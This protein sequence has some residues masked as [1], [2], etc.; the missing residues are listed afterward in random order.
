MREKIEQNI[1]EKVKVHERDRELEKESLNKIREKKQKDKD[2]QK[3][4]EEKR[5]KGF[6]CVFFTSVAPEI[7]KTEIKKVG[8][9]RFN[10]FSVTLHNL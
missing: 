9:R 2:G 3:E 8:V 7:N 10:R 5:K 4:R 6:Y 1:R